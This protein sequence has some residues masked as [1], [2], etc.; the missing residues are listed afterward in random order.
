MKLTLN[1]LS[2]KQFYLVHTGGPTTGISLSL[3]ELF[4]YLS[5]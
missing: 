1:I 3:A 2:F 4:R 5:P